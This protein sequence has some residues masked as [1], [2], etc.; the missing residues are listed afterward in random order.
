MFA[1]HPLYPIC[2]PREEGFLRVSKI[3]S[4]FY[5][6]YG[7]PEGI[8][9]VVLHGGPGAGCSDVLSRLFDLSRW[10]VFM[11]DQR[12]AMRSEP[13][14]SMEENSSQHLVADIE[15]LRIHFGIE[16]WIVFGGSWGATLALLYGEAHPERCIGFILRGIFLAREQ[17]WL[18]L[19]YAMGK[20]FPEGYEPCLEHIPEEERGDLISAYYRRLFDPDPDV[21]MRAAEAF[22]RFDT[23]CATHLPNP[24][25]LEQTMQNEKLVLGVAK[26]FFYYAKNR[27]FLEPNQIL[28]QIGKIAHLPTII[29]QG[30]WDAITLPE[31]AYLLHK[32]WAGSKLWMVPDGGHSSNDP[33]IAAALATATDFF[34]EEVK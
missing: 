17:D 34:K 20:I 32:S 7:N 16:K 15:A 33:A 24:A 28:D 25:A 2:V 8:P 3:H 18:H 21:Q 10:N 23:I 6:A 12:G 30:R 13:F 4:L 27:F 29:V 11:F 14:A 22:M 5:A 19:V 31:M 1:D 9:I 26:A